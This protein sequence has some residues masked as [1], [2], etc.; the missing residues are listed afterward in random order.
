MATIIQTGEYEVGDANP[1]GTGIDRTLR[2][3]AKEVELVETAAR[4]A[5]PITDPALYAAFSAGYFTKLFDALSTLRGYV[6]AQ[7]GMDREDDSSPARQPL[8][9]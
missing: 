8:N 2:N 9:D 3:I 1:Y 5:D 4:K 7:C 6:T